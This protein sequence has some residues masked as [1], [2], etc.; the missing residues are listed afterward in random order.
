MKETFFYL[1]PLFGRT[2]AQLGP[3]VNKVQLCSRL[4][5]TLASVCLF[6]T[7][8]H[9]GAIRARLGAEDCGRAL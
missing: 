8:P 1:L 7:T 6:F 9:R 5:V 3:A 2:I 4:V